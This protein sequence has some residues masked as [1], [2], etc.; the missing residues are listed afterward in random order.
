MA[1]KQVVRVVESAGARL[2][3]ESAGSGPILVLI[4]GGGGDAAVY[5]DVVELL[6]D[7]YTVIT[8]DRRGNSRSVLTEPDAEIGIEA[9]A[10]DVVAILDAHGVD[11]AQVFGSSGGAI[12]ALELIAHHSERLTAAVAHEPPLVQLLGSD[13][14][15]RQEITRIGQLAMDKSPMRAFAAFGVMTAPQLP[16]VLRSQAGQAIMAAGSTA[17]LALGPAVRRITGR[18]PSPM[19]RILGNTDL[20]LR[21]ELPSFCF[22]YRPDLTALRTTPVPWRPAVGRDSTGRPYFVAAQALATQLDTTCTEFPGGHTVYQT[23]PGEFADRLE[24]AFEE[25]VG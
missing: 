19:T 3:T 18:S 14:P 7:R 5:E 25:L 8:F 13:D 16:A 4:S 9:Q 23:H 10:A 11:R 6:A 17:A 12:I 22:D 15:A 20:L 21:R 2:H 1:R 24:T